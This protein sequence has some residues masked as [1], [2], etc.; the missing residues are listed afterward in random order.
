[1]ENLQIYAARLGASVAT[2]EP[3]LHRVTAIEPQAKPTF[4]DA[5][6]R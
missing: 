2:A 4:V 1:M 5:L 3:N 6:P